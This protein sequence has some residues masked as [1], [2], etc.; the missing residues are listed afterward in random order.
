M[1]WSLTHKICTPLVCNGGKRTGRFHEKNDGLGFIWELVRNSRLEES[2]QSQ[3]DA[4]PRVNAMCLKIEAVTSTKKV[5]LRP[6]I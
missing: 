4:V 1:G 6:L 3:L 2:L 5:R